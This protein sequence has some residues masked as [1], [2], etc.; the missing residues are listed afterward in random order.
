[1]GE[2]SAV[3]MPERT[4]TSFANVDVDQTLGALSQKEKIDLLSGEL[5]RYV[6]GR[7]VII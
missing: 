3:V 5:K 1:M 7:T 6:A 4:K 2:V